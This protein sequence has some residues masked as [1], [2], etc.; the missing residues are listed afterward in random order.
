MAP[1]RRQTRRRAQ[2]P[3][4]GRGANLQDPAGATTR[5]STAKAPL[6][7]SHDAIADALDEAGHDDGL[8][9]PH[10]A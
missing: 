3:R 9:A 10:P 5:G 4:V 6:C 7:L 8:A 1:E 2:Q